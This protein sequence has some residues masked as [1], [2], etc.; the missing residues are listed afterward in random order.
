MSWH[1]AEQLAVVMNHLIA[2]G[3]A[4]CQGC[5]LPLVDPDAE[6]VGLICFDCN[7]IT[8]WHKGCASPE[9][10]AVAA[11]DGRRLNWRWN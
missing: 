2:A 10:L 5:T 3:Y 7:E 4:R 6:H 1:T 8:I 11:S 9:V